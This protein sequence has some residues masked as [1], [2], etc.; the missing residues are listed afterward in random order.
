MNRQLTLQQRLELVN[1]LTKLSKSDDDIVPCLRERFM[2]DVIYTSIG[3]SSLVV[4]NPHKYVDSNADS[5]L[6][7]Y[8]AE[9]RNIT[10][11]KE[12]LLPH[13][14]QLANNGYYHTKRMMQDQAIVFR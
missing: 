8:A 9:F 7:N 4:F 1:D 5:V 11:N 12:L 14:F 6:H 2:T 13:I 10:F 3:F